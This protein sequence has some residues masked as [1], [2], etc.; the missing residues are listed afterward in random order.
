MP[1]FEQKSNRLSRLTSSLL[2]GVSLIFPLGL[3]AAEQA[4]QP[5]SELD[6]PEY[7]DAQRNYLSKEFVNFVA[8]IDRFFG[9]DRNYLETNKSVIQIDLTKVSGYGGSRNPVFSGRAKLDMPSAEKRLHLL[10]ESDPE[11]TITGETT[12]GQPVVQNK[13][14]TP[15]KVAVGAGY[16][17]EKETRWHFS[18]DAGIQIHSPVEPFARA[19]GSYSFPL[20]QWRMKAAETLFWFSTIGAGETTQLDLEHIL[21]EPVLFR[22]SSVATWLRDK[23][24]FDLRQDLSIYHTLNDRS[25]LLYQ[26]SAIGVSNP[27]VQATEFVLAMVYRYRLRQK[28][29]FLE[30]SPQLHFP[31]ADNFKSNPALSMRL[32]I[33]FDESR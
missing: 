9:D 6:T 24:N 26:A 31:K 3:L 11:K 23:H 12:P 5:V 13:V 16:V 29:I 14:V 2:L 30:L 4:D 1:V 25:A 8:D 22:A 17:K 21:S 7:I 32:E 19:R 28:W 18:A 15:E 20:E 27:Q 10:L 33:L